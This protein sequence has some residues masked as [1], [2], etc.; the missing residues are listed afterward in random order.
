MCAAP[1][2]ASLGKEKRKLPDRLKFLRRLDRIGLNLADLGKMTNTPECVL[3][4]V[5]DGRAEP[6]AAMM[7]VAELFAGCHQEQRT[8][9]VSLGNSGYQWRMIVGYS[10]YEASEAG[11]IR[12]RLTGNATHPG[13]ELKQ[14]LERGYL[15]VKLYADDGKQR[16]LF[17]SRAVCLAFH[18]PANGLSA[19]HR[20]GIRSD[21]REG[22]LYWGTDE[23]NHADR[24]FHARN[25]RQ[26]RILENGNI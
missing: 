9:A 21:N 1:W 13:R 11:S 6:T 14:R 12:R 19:C 25:G 16:T 15:S 20:N 2:R 22:N 18:G 7:A 5:R 8:R 26:P 23:E 4:D 17:V 24:R 3:L 10:G